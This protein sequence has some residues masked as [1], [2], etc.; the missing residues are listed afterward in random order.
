MGV[1]GR[2]SEE[3]VRISMIKRVI[4]S[5]VLA[6]MMVAT[7]AV[8]ALAQ[9]NYGHSHTDHMHGTISWDWQSHW[10]TAGRH[11][12]H[13]HWQDTA[14]GDSGAYTRSF[15]ISSPCANAALE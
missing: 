10:T 9:H 7:L 13:W 12:M 1:A 3:E 8:S 5:L 11:Y 4:V 6:A 15:C 2:E 14:S